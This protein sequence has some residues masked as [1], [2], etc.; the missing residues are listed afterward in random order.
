VLSEADDVSLQLANAVVKQRNQ[1]MN[2]NYSF[3]DLIQE[4]PRGKHLAKLRF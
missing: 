2:S 1:L 4:I 3:D